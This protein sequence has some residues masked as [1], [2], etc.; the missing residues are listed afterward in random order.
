ME[1]ESIARANNITADTFNHASNTQRDNTK[2]IIKSE[3]V[4]KSDDMVD[5]VKNVTINNDEYYESQTATA[6]DAQGDLI[7]NPETVTHTRNENKAVTH[8]SN[9]DFEKKIE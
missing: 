8:N 2:T 4:D 5:A 7:Q 1:E 6:S 9:G 3:K